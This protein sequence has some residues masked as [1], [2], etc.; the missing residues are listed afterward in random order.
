VAYIIPNQ[1][2]SFIMSGA[3]AG[4]STYLTLNLYLNS[5]MTGLQANSLTATMASANVSAWTDTLHGGYSG[6]QIH[7][8]AWSAPYLSAGSAE[9]SASGNDPNGFKFSFTAAP[10][11]SAFGYVISNTAANA[12]I[13]VESFA[14]SYYL[15]NAGDTITIKPKIR[16]S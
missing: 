14:A 2:D 12:C 11:Q 13:V 8:S 5:A 10:N 3:F 1:G 15:S 9:V 4:S 6:L 16:A 7:K